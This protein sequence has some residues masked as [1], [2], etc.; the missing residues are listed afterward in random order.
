MLGQH[1]VAFYRGYLEGVELARPAD[2]YLEAGLDL[3]LAGATVAWIEA[4][5]A[6]G[7]RRLSTRQAAG[8]QALSRSTRALAMS[9]CNLARQ[10]LVGQMLALR[11]AASE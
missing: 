5:L 8:I 4:E 11:E 6:R 3:R 9:L 1:H 7:V 2:R 10:P